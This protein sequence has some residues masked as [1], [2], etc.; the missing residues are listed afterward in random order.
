MRKQ[1]PSAMDETRKDAKLISKMTPLRRRGRKGE[2]S[3]VSDSNKG[4]QR[5]LAR[6]KQEKRMTL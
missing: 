2:T 1:T 6:L 5:N 4:K 3:C